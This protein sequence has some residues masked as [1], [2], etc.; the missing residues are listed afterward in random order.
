MKPKRRE[1]QKQIWCDPMFAQE[2]YK[3]KAHRYF[4]GKPVSNVGDLTKEIINTPEWKRVTDYL[5]GKTEK[6]RIKIDKKRGL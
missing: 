5:L 2:L 4:N 6:Q 3:I 1:R